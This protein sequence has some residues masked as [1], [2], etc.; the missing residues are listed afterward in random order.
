MNILQELKKIL[1]KILKREKKVS[2]SK[3][4]TNR[5]RKRRV[6]RS[7]N[8]AY[9]NVMSKYNKGSHPF[10]VPDLKEEYQKIE[11]EKEKQKIK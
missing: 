4:R 5:N 3:K 8:E 9:K 1:L 7:N 2:Y 11:D 6:S 10:D